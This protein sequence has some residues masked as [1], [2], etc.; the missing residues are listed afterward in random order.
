MGLISEQRGEFQSM[1]ALAKN[2]K[3]CGQC[4]TNQLFRYYTPSI[5]LPSQV[6]STA[7]INGFLFIYSSTPLRQNFSKPD[8][9]PVGDQLTGTWLSYS[10]SFICI[11]EATIHSKL[12][13][14]Y[15]NYR[16]PLPRHFVIQVKEFFDICL[17]EG[18]CQFDSFPTNWDFWAQLKTRT[19]PT[20]QSVLTRSWTI[21]ITNTHPHTHPIQSN[22][23]WMK[24]IAFSRN[25][26]ETISWWEIGISGTIVPQQQQ[27]TTDHKHRGLS[28][29]HR[30]SRI[31]IR[32]FRSSP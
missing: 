4:K 19:S 6:T 22:R 25:S 2:A 1:P 12:R 29:Y 7:Q 20:K 13:H 27:A 11:L 5:S 8:P 23:C 21:T 24:T 18:N 17:V 3:Q 32:F 9:P 31:S 14:C 10:I 28:H 30:S 26:I 15:I 16:P